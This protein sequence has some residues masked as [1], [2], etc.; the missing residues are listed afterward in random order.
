MRWLRRLRARL[1]GWLAAA[2][3]TTAADREGYDM[4][5]DLSIEKFSE[6][7]AA[8][9]PTPGGGSAA[10]LSGAL[11]ASLLRMVCDLT[12]G[13]EKFRAQQQDLEAIR[14]RVEG[15]RRDL[16]ALVDR[17][18]QAFEDVM[19]ARR[20]PRGSEEEKRVRAEALTRANQFATET[21]LATAEACAALVAASAEV[22]EKG[23]PNALSD[24]AT[25]AL[26]AC[27]GLRSALMN[28]RINLAD[29]PPG[30][31]ARAAR[32]RERIDRLESEAERGRSRA[33]DLF[34]RSVS[35]G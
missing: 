21:P 6:H 4:L 18:A 19:E 30:D 10:A 1:A 25:G 16:I 35:I 12:I 33:I 2:S 15:Y 8:G 7:L 13:K 20:S 24:A 14:G 23:N 32:I 3:G 11:A 27:A 26:L 22:M 31:A 17:D 29:L 34:T 9:T 5:K 28:V